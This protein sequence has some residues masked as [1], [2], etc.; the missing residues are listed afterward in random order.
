MGD[1]L[2]AYALEEQNTLQEKTERTNENK[3]SWPLPSLNMISATQ[4]IKPLKVI[5]ATKCT[6]PVL[7]FWQV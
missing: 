2:S 1:F 3:Y 4:S 6:V 7:N 5:A